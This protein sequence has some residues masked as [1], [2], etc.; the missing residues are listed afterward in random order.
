LPVRVANLG[1]IWTVCY[2]APSRYNWMLQYYLRLEGLHLPW[3]GTGRFIF[4][5]DYSDADFAAVCDR[6]MAA[7][8]AMQA[9]G[10]WWQDAGLTEKSI[11]RRVLA[12]LRQSW[13]R[14]CIGSISS[15]RRRASGA[16]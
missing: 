3:I 11:K 6:F 16:R 1:S 14:A 2:T 8:R 7:A 4:S 15:P 10:W 5:L 13:W 12:E 9:D